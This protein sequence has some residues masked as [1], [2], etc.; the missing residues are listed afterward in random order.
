LGCVVLV[1]ATLLTVDLSFCLSIFDRQNE[2]GPISC[3][4]ADNKTKIR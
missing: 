3:I 2:G 1:L 4:D